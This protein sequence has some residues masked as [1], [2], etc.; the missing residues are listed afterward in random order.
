MSHINS[1]PPAEGGDFP[2]IDMPLDGSME[3]AILDIVVSA[4]NK[5]G[6]P[7]LDV[8]SLRADAAHREAALDM[9]RDCRPLP[10]VRQLIEKMEAGLV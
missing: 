2:E 5:Q 4:L 6:Y 3:Q 7:G 9:L 10:V 8:D 1:K